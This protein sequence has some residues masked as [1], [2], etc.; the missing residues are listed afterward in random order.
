MAVFGS[1][2][3]NPVPD[4]EHT[5]YALIIGENPR[6]S[7]MSFLAISIPLS[8]LLSGILLVWVVRRARAGDYDDWEGPAERMIH[9]DDR[10]PEREG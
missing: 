6:V 5:D 9:D 4:L 2:T 1:G 8:L 7:H 10:L 3:I